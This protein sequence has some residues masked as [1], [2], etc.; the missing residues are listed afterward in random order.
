MTKEISFSFLL[1]VLKSAWWKMLIFTVAVA[2]AVAAFTEFFVPKKYQSSVEFYI[3]NTSTT[4][5]YVTSSLL[6]SATYLASDYV[7]ILNSDRMITTIIT[8]LNGAGYTNV[9]ATAVRNML[10]SAAST[11]SSTFYVIATSTDRDLAYTIARSIQDHAPQILREVTRPTYTSNLYQKIG[12]EFAKL[13]ESDLECVVP[14]RSPQ[15]AKTHS[16]P[17]I[18]VNT[19]LAAML[20]LLVSYVFFLMRKLSDTTIRSESSFR[21][22]VGSSVTI[23]GTIPY[24]HANATDK[25]A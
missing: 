3:L 1:K 10:S 24:W 13:D 5:E 17:S 12:D 21:D 8:D 25:N 20:A 11:D 16:S 15:V 19:M 7:K 18:V 4:S 6:E 14:V 22:A 23:I 9:S 2:A